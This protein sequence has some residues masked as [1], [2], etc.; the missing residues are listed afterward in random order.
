MDRKS[1]GRRVLPFALSLKE[2]RDEYLDER[3]QLAEDLADAKDEVREIEAT[4]ES[5]TSEAAKLGRV[6]QRCENYS[7]AWQSRIQDLVKMEEELKRRHDC[8]EEYNGKMAEEPQ[9][10]R[11]QNR[12]LRRELEALETTL[13]KRSLD[14]EVKPLR[15]HKNKY[16][17]HTKEYRRM[18]DE[19]R[20]MEEKIHELEQERKKA[21]RSMRNMSGVLTDSIRHLTG[22]DEGLPEESSGDEMCNQKGDIANQLKRIAE[23]F[24]QKEE[25]ANQLKRIA[26]KC[27][28]KEEI[29]NQL[30][31][32]ADK[33]NPKEE[34]ANQLKLIAKKCNPKEETDDEK[35]ITKEYMRVITEAVKKKER[36]ERDSKSKEMTCDEILSPSQNDSASAVSEDAPASI[37]PP[38][39]EEQR[40]YELIHSLG[41]DE[42]RI[43]ELFLARSPSESQSGIKADIGRNRQLRKEAYCNSNTGSEKPD[44]IDYMPYPHEYKPYGIQSFSEPRFSSENRSGHHPGFRMQSP[45]HPPYLG[46]SQT[47]SCPLN[48]T[49][50]PHVSLDPF[51][52]YQFVPDSLPTSYSTPQMSVHSYGVPPPP[53]PPPPPFEGISS[54]QPQMQANAPP[55]PYQYSPTPS[56]QLHGMQGYNG[57]TTCRGAVPKMNGDVPPEGFVRHESHPCPKNEGPMKNE[58]S[59]TNGNYDLLSGR[60]IRSELPEQSKSGEVEAERHPRF[61]YLKKGASTLKPKAHAQTEGKA[62]DA[63]RQRLR[64][65]IRDGIPLGFRVRNDGKIIPASPWAPEYRPPRGDPSYP[66]N[67]LYTTKRPIERNDGPKKPEFQ[68]PRWKI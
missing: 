17:E 37:I 19:F 51:Q 12:K 4:I 34:I 28:P 10:L 29:T 67:W 52:L 48:L 39:P 57:Q 64:K 41:L 55:C 45:R 65:A 7:K 22:E 9:S 13:S 18:Q 63:A 50:V 2:L 5:Q 26:D 68:G 20:D 59:A 54:S 6:I 32:I 31:R 44:K 49:P 15:R 60:K 35:A 27:N 62:S 3:R 1:G 36:M 61:P 23:K 14:L 38:F 43:K 53:P 8:M 66:F 56:E 24:N 25:I 58:N 16:G 40:V 33:C 30:K 42:K 47:R 46:V 21:Y 11:E